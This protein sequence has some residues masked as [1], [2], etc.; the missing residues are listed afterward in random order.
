MRSKTFF[1]TKSIIFISAAILLFLVS[2]FLVSFI[3][4]LF[5]VSDIAYLTDFGN[6]G[7]GIFL[8]VFPWIPTILVLLV[9]LVLGWILEHYAFVYRKPLLYL[10][11]TLIGS[12]TVFSFIAH[13]V[14]FHD[15]LSRL[16]HRYQLPV[17]QQFYGIYDIPGKG[18]ITRGLITD[19]EPHV[20]QIMSSSNRPISVSV[21]ENTVFTSKIINIGDEIVIFGNRVEDN[22]EAFGIEMVNH[23]KLNK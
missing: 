20:W 10:P 4:Y 1:I 11:L 6:R 2:I 21:S 12:I 22:V 17:L 3:F 8:G 7:W 9:T 15:R 19:I 14:A 23:G 16:S 18:K 5:R 13:T